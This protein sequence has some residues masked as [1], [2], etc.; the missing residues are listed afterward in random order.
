LRI[1]DSLQ[2]ITF[3]NTLHVIPYKKKNTVQKMLQIS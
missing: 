1:L 3:C 2:L